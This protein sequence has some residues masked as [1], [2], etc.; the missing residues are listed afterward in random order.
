MSATRIDEKAGRATI[1]TETGPERE[2]T[3]SGPGRKASMK[4]MD[5]GGGADISHSISDGKVK[6]L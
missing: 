2:K 5:K 1:R 6:K 4:M 3:I